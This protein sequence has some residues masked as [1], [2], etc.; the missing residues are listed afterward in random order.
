MNLMILTMR[1][2][3]A[4]GKDKEEI[5]AGRMDMNKMMIMVLI[6]EEALAAIMETAV[7]AEWEM[8]VQTGEQEVIKAAT[9][10]QDQVAHL[11]MAMEMEVGVLQTEEKTKVQIGAPAVIRAAIAVV[12]RMNKIIWEK[13]VVN[14]VVLKTKEEEGPVTVPVQ[15]ETIPQ[16][17]L[18]ADAAVAAVIGNCSV[19]SIRTESKDFLTQQDCKKKPGSVEPGF[20]FISK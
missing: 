5:K 12:I 4:I 8:K 3:A 19:R 15:A 17:H 9:A 18:Q 2:V 6:Q 16:D 13:A 1:R 11:I 14:H 10:I 20:N 7:V